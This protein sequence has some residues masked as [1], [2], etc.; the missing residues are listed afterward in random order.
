MSINNL[1]TEIKE[2]IIEIIK[3]VK[4]E[5]VTYDE[6]KR[7]LL[8]EDTEEN[9]SNFDEVINELVNEYKLFINK[10]GYLLNDRK[11]NKFIGTISIRNND[12]GFVTNDYCDDFYV[13]GFDIYSLNREQYLYP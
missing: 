9:N 7:M 5:P 8:L 12:Y 4:Y 11:A 2:S 6:M 13:D 10:K 3:N 1:K